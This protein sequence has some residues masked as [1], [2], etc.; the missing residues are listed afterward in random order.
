MYLIAENI[1]FESIFLFVNYD[2]CKTQC[3]SITTMSSPASNN[4]KLITNYYYTP[5]TC[6]KCEG[7]IK[8]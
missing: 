8:R 6:N 5:N 3:D 4:V 7:N 1:T 2:K